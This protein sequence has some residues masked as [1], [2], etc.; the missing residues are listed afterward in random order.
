VLDIESLDF[1]GISPDEFA[2]LVK[3]MSKREL[4]AITG[5]PSRGRIVDAILARM[6]AA[7]N[8]EA[9]GRLKAL[10]R[11]RIVDDDQPDIGFEMAI[12]DG[13][14]EVL[15]DISDREPRVEL[16]M[17]AADFARLASGNA[18]GTALF[19]TRRLKVA[20]DLGLAA[21]LVRYFDIPKA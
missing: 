17:S 2:R 21:S 5:G 9:A 8:P 12:A 1:S 19:M 4:A 11:W 10:I 16:T 14:C 15:T 6:A 13:T 3:G 7:F 20:G 18:S